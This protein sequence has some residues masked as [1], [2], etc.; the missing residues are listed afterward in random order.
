[1][2]E[3]VTRDDALLCEARREMYAALSKYADGYSST[4]GS[5]VTTFVAVAE[6][7]LGDGRRARIEVDGDAD[8]E[9]ARSAAIT[10]GLMFGYL[11]ER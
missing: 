9:R 4:E 11:F 5:V 1:M 8:G 10:Y 2:S 3:D 6:V 7:A